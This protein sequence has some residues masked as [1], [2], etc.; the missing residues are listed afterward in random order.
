MHFHCRK[1]MCV[2]PCACVCVCPKC[3]CVF[4]PVCMCVCVPQCACV[5]VPQCACVCA[6]S[7]Y[8]YMCMSQCTC[9]CPHVMRR[10]AVTR[11]ESQ[12]LLDIRTLHCC[13]HSFCCS[14]LELC[15][16]LVALSASSPVHEIQ[17]S[18]HIWG[19]HL[20]GSAIRALMHFNCGQKFIT[21]N[22]VHFNV[23]CHQNLDSSL[24]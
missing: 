1:V 18:H 12:H 4:A 5:C 8:V 7:V 20:L 17:A 23:N 10:Q 3:V 2:C 16:N 15:L 22:S 9:T 19:V 14:L 13:H 11:G 6:P 21:L 24:L